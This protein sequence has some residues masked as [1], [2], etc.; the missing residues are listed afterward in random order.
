M[1]AIS[2]IAVIVGLA[3]A[4]CD[5]GN[6]NGPSGTSVGRAG[7]G[8]DSTSTPPAPDGAGGGQ[9]TLCTRNFGRMSAQIDGTAWTASCVQSAGYTVGVLSIVGT[10]GTDVV[11]LGVRATVPGT[12]DALSGSAIGTIAR[13]NGSAWTSG[14]GG[15]ASVTLTRIELGGATGTFSFTAPPVP[16]TTST[17]VRTVTAGAFNVTF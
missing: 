13:A 8:T 17:G 16:G 7:T 3:L 5:D 4:A 2:I 12:Y 14:P 11:T 10:N 15:T 6:P 1:R 9:S